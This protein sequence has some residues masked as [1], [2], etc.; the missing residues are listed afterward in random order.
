MEEINEACA[1]INSDGAYWAVQ[2]RAMMT[3]RGGTSSK[4]PIPADLAV[5]VADTIHNMRSALDH[6]VYRFARLS[7]TGPECGDCGLQRRVDVGV[8]EQRLPTRE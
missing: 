4:W 6:A 8:V 2:K 7:G 5:M 1:A 3:S